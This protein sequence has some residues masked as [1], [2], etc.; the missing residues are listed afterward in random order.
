MGSTTTAAAQEELI[1]LSSCVFS[2]KFA[3]G[4]RTLCFAHFRMPV[5]LLLKWLLFFLSICFSFYPYNTYRIEGWI[6]NIL[7]L[8]FLEVNAQPL[9][10]QCQQT[11]HIRV[12]Q[13]ENIYCSEI[14]TRIVQ[15]S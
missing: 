7:I 12:Y 14:Y 13:D 5:E 11:R 9:Q 4:Y 8:K 15:T 10:R 2:A 6:L 1:E 3:L